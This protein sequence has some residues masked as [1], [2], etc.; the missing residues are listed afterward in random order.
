MKTNTIVAVAV[1][2]T[3]VAGFGFV[4]ADISNLTGGNNTTLNQTNSTIQ[5]T[6][7]QGTAQNSSTTSEPS[8]DSQSSDSQSSS[9]TNSKSSNSNYDP[10]APLGS[11]QN[12]YQSSGDGGAISN[13][14]NHLITPNSYHK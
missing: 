11:S 8:K 7:D 6:T 5:N 3:L 13:N 2:V 1:A 14:T 4:A 12:P 9:S 10:S